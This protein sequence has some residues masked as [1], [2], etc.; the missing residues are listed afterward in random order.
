M[1]SIIY[2]VASRMKNR[3]SFVYSLFAEQLGVIVGEKRKP[4]SREET[5]SPLFIRPFKT[6]LE[7]IFQSD[8]NDEIIFSH[9]SRF[10][11]FSVQNSSRN[12]FTAGQRK[13]R[14]RIKKQHDIEKQEFDSTERE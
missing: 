5:N 14:R 3:A 11:G 8:L 9:D 7:N 2:G 10:R 4:L 13:N 1:A 6:R 12:S